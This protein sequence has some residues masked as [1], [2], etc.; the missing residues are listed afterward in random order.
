VDK[1][2]FF[3]SDEDNMKKKYYKRTKLIEMESYKFWTADGD[4]T[5]IMQ[6][7]EIINNEGVIG[8]GKE[9]ASLWR[10]LFAHLMALM[11]DDNK[12]LGEH[13]VL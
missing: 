6:L 5:N 3:K 1:N 2:T 9:M 8:E 10:E 12:S 4:D 13:E 11:T 7:V